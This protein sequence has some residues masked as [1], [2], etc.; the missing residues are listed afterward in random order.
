MEEEY[1]KVY[2]LLVAD[3]GGSHVLFHYI[4]DYQWTYYRQLADE[5]NVKQLGKAIELLYNHVS[6]ARSKNRSDF[7]LEVYRLKNE[8]NE[9]EIIATEW[10]ALCEEYSPFHR[11]II[12]SENMFSNMK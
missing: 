9:F 6:G 5:C 7:R 10:L 4:A 1:A 12:A 2:K 11:R 3:K 8:E